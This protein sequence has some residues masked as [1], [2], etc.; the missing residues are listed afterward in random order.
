M[1]RAER[2]AYVVR[3]FAKGFGSAEVEVYSIHPRY[4]RPCASDMEAVE[5]YWERELTAAYGP[6]VAVGGGVRMM[7]A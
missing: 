2:L 3:E 5:E 4:L 7:A 1:D 6:L